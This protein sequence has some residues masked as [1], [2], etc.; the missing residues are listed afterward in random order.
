VIAACNAKGTF[1]EGR[2]I[3]A[4]VALASP[5]LSRFDLILILLDHQKRS[6][7]PLVPSILPEPEPLVDSRLVWDR[8]L[9]DKI[10]SS[11]TLGNLQRTREEAGVFWDWDVLRSYVTHLRSSL[12]PQ[13]SSVAEALL[14]RYYQHQRRLDTRQAARTTVRLLESL[15]RL[16]QAHAKLM[17]QRVVELRDAIVAIV[18]MEASLWSNTESLIGREH[19]DLFAEAE[20]DSSKAE[21]VF[22][23]LE[24]E[25]LLKLEVNPDCYPRRADAMMEGNGMKTANTMD[26]VDEQF[27]ESD[28]MDELLEALAATNSHSQSKDPHGHT[29]TADTNA[30]AQGDRMSDLSE[31]DES[32]TTFP[33]TLV[34]PTWAPSQM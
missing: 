30:S 21:A 22:S 28:G 27:E 14:S 7:E 19:L 12:N 10:L 13:L 32:F 20:G 5:L 9:C 6:Q 34:R 29:Q 17:Y 3:T 4:N 31:L 33:A 23:S 1:E 25:I 18:F 26:S 8:K 2:S 24:R 16:A 11:V 15:V